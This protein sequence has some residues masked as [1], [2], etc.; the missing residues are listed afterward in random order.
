MSQ[1][2]AE[3]PHEWDKPT[4]QK[5]FENL[6]SYFSSRK[7]SLEIVVIGGVSVVYQGFQNRSTNDIDVAP[8]ADA[9]KF[10][11]ACLELGIDAQ[12]IS[13]STTVD[14]HAVS[15]ILLF[16]GSSLT[17]FSASP[18]ELIC[19]KLER[20]RK[21]DPEDIYSIIQKE[22]IP[23]DDFVNL[24]QDAVSSFVGRVETYRIAAQIV[25]E[26]MYPDQAEN[27]QKDIIKKG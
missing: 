26:T 15:K 8:V 7:E 11:K 9:D 24:V 27:F 2:K 20:F 13:I 10:L 6:D 23:Y 14:F 4:I 22:N 3:Y 16:Q 18:K 1:G 25:V 5:I 12:S 17:V 21:Q 19:L